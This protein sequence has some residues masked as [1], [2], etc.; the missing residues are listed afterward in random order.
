MIDILSEISK[1]LNFTYTLHAAQVS[2]LV[3]NYSTAIT[4]EF[5]NGTVSVA[6]WN[7]R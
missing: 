3:A 5:T 7:Y 1:K 4:E 2:A 6:C